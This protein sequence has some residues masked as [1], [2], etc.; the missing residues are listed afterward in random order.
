MKTG[1]EIGVNAEQATRSWKKPGR[2]LPLSFQ[3][4]HS[5]ACS[6]ISDFLVPGTVREHISVVLSHQVFVW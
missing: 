4:E 1:A 6:L 2:I 3:R 5:P